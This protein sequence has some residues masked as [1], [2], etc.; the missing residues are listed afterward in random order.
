VAARG[1]G[2][3]PTNAWARAEV[4]MFRLEDGWQRSDVTVFERCYSEE[5]S[6]ALE[7][8][9]FRDLRALDARDGGM[10]GDTGLGRSFFF[11]VK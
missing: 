8:A 10:R 2:T 5:E 1:A 7:R 4:T 9:G 3:I 11:A 6:A